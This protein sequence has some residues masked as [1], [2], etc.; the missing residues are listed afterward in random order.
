[1]PSPKGIIFDLGD[2]LMRFEFNLAQGIVRL[3]ELANNQKGVTFEEFTKAGKSL[4][5]AMVE[6]FKNSPFDFPQTSFHRHLFDRLG[7]TF[8]LPEEVVDHEFFTSTYQF[9]PIEGVERMLQQLADNR[10]R[11]GI[12][13]NSM[14]TGKSLTSALSKF[15]LLRYFEFLMSSADYGF[16]KPHQEIFNTAVIRL[17]LEPKE[18]WFVGDRID[19]DVAGAQNAGL[20]AIWFNSQNSP[21]SQPHPDAEIHSW[22]EFNVLVT[23]HLR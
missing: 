8:D 9:E 18:V 22:D 11:M 14:A 5:T 20:S 10:I 7:L 19:I 3:L 21:P 16:R 6:A 17:G 1:L 4:E 12:V 15:N 13:S 23:T 2:T